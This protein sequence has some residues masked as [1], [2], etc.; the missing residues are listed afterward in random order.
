MHCQ[1]I[2]SCIHN[3]QLNHSLWYRT[4]IIL[5]SSPT[6]HPGV[7]MQFFV[8]PLPCNSVLQ[9]LASKNI[10]PSLKPFTLDPAGTKTRVYRQKWPCHPALSRSEPWATFRSVRRAQTCN[11]LKTSCVV[12]K[13]YAVDE[14]DDGVSTRVS[15][16]IYRI[17]TWKYYLQCLFNE[18][19]KH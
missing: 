9:L 11:C 7:A 14:S 10:S 8:L 13:I 15:L 5:S 4:C 2:H 1:I 18:V 6:P 17:K 16:H 19:Q 12:W 3:L